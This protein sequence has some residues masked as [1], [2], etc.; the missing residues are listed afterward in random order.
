MRRFLG[1]LVV[2]WL[3]QAIAED[4]AT[5]GVCADKDKGSVGEEPTT[6]QVI[7]DGSLR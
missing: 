1:L 2:A 3:G 5:A 4:A 7:S 6:A